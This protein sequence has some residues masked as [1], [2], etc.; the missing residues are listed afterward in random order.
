MGSLQ[1]QQ[2][3]LTQISLTDILDR[4]PIVSKRQKP[5]CSLSEAVQGDNVY[6]SKIARNT[7]EDIVLKWIKAQL[8]DVLTF[9]GAFGVTSEMQ[10]I[11]VARHILKKYYYMTMLEL[12]YFFESFIGGRYGMLYVG[13]TINAQIILQALRA[14]D[15]DVINMRAEKEQEL[16]ARRQQKEQSEGIDGWREF[17]K[18]KGISDQKIPMQKYLR[19]LK[20]SLILNK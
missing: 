8:I 4:Y 5:I 12:T 11:I 9:C 13:K 1:K 18:N 10:V 2:P 15:F 7:G 20:K 19:A 6:L 17:C 16:D 3:Y 14:F